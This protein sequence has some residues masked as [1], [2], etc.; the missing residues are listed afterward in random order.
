MSFILSMAALG[1][2]SCSSRW[3]DSG[4]SSFSTNSRID[5]LRSLRSS[6]SSKFRPSGTSVV[7]IGYFLSL[8]QKL[9]AALAEKGGDAFC[10]VLGLHDFFNALEVGRVAGRGTVVE[11]SLY[12]ALDQAHRDRPRRRCELAPEVACLREQLVVR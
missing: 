3:S 10:R 4:H 1:I 8:T 5:R 2:S 11:P 9:R 12:R 7:A 6:G